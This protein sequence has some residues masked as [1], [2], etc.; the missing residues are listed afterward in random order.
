VAHPASPLVGAA[1][2]GTSS[3]FPS[4]AARLGASH[5][6][7]VG[8]RSGHDAAV[9]SGQVRA[10]RS[11]SCCARCWRRACSAGCSSR[12]ASLREDSTRIPSRATS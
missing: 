3:A 12:W 4:A 2:N 7:P 11:G 10:S 6:A 5:E 9:G 8:G 1:A